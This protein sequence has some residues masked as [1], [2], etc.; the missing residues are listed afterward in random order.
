MRKFT[1]RP[2]ERLIEAFA[3]LPGI[4]PKTASRL[5]FYLL[6]S[7]ES[8]SLELAEALHEM[9]AKTRLCSRCFNIS[10][11]DAEVCLDLH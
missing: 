1:P 4:G 2:V 8:E 5:T 11:S 3:R 10:T 7:P 6:R 9:K